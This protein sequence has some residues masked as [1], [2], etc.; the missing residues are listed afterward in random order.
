[1]KYED[2]SNASD[3]SKANTRANIIEALKS[4]H[5]PQIPVS[6]LDLGFIYS[7]TVTPEKG[8]QIEMTAG[9]P[10]CPAVTDMSL[11]VRDAISSLL[12]VS[13]VTV[14]VVFDPLWNKDMISEEG[15]LML[16]LF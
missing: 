1:M 9:T 14:D 8:V 5:D 4:V 11:Q 16:D 15:R 13:Y 6:V 7:V 3:P 10:D 12:C 2:F